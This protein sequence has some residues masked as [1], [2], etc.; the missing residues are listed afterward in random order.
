[1]FT[2]KNPSLILLMQENLKRNVTLRDGSPLAKLGAGINFECDGIDELLAGYDQDRVHEA[3]MTQLEDELTNMLNQRISFIRNT[4][5]STI[6]DID[7]E[8]EAELLE[9]AP[10]QSPVNIITASTP[11][12][13]TSEFLVGA[14]EKYR[15]V[16]F[17]DLKAKGFPTLSKAEIV[18]VAQKAFDD[19][20]VLSMVNDLIDTFDVSIVDIYEAHFCGKRVAGYPL[21]F[22]YVRPAYTKF[23]Y[24]E[25]A[26][27]FI[28]AWSFYHN[29]HPQVELS[30]KDYNVVT[31][32]ILAQAGRKLV[33]TLETIKESERRI[34]K[35][36]VA[37]E[38]RGPQTTIVLNRKMYEFF[39]TLP[40]A[41][42]ETII[43]MMHLGR[44]GDIQF[45][46]MDEADWQYGA[47]VT[48][49]NEAF[50]RWNAQRS[51]V[52]NSDR[53]NAAIKL[54]LKRVEA[55]AGDEKF[56]RP[57]GRST[58]EV[59]QDC[60]KVAENF[61]SFSMDKQYF[62]IRE[63]VCQ[64]LYPHAGALTYLKAMDRYQAEN[65]S[66]KPREAATL[67]VCDVLA[68][69]GCNQLA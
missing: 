64:G 35:L 37:K 61:G 6:E 33:Q 2:L 8:V 26:L 27:V 46:S 1:M 31:S 25:Q 57:N 69:F 4:V 42:P 18:E 50:G 63:I 19:E 7:A 20:E 22:S 45:T 13:L 9:R 67:A 30:L 17:K 32:D 29:P 5:V 53:R 49:A 68:E 3:F 62:F 51:T 11:A 15:N 16:S 36:L 40:D 44:L 52:V 48:K 23:T 12:L 66:I 60:R 59:R 65:P 21:P 55:I 28:L 39:L 54:V 41:K 56:P 24:V 58:E 38:E 34:S 47:L 10:A 43:G 14:V